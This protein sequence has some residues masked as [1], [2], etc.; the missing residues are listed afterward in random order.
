LFR[1]LFLTT[2]SYSLIYKTNATDTLHHP[3]RY[4]IPDPDLKK[5]LIRKQ[6]R[7]EGAFD[8]MIR[9]PTIEQRE[10]KRLLS[11]HRNIPLCKDKVR[12]EMMVGAKKKIVHLLERYE[13]TGGDSTV[14][15]LDKVRVPTFKEMSLPYSELADS[16]FHIDSQ[17]AEIFHAEEKKI[18]DDDTRYDGMDI[19]VER[20]LVSEVDQ[21][22]LKMISEVM[23]LVGLDKADMIKV[24][25]GQ[26]KV[27]LFSL[28]VF[29][30]CLL[31]IVLLFGDFL[32]MFV[33]AFVVCCGG[34]VVVIVVWWCVVVDVGVVEVEEVL[35]FL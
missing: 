15:V 16:C 34:V 20:L 24:R 26:L 2:L 27:C 25:K 35:L 23:G 31:Q 17:V 29:V 4:G 19:K 11:L 30:V 5:E 12:K 33:G 7:S 22:L 9:G 13:Q 18:S 32:I 8:N 1:L 6:F 21:A 10:A 28:F 3:F 14:F